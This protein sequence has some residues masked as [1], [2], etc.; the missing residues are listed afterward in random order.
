MPS[1]AVCT[2]TTEVAISNAP[3]MPTSEAAVSNAMPLLVPEGDMPEDLKDINVGDLLPDMRDYEDELC[4]F[5][6]AELIPD[7]CA[8]EPLPANDVPA[9]AAVQG[10]GL[11]HEDWAEFWVFPAIQD[12]PG[13]DDAYRTDE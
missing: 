13:A 9:D 6:F 7:Y 10:A 4:D 12:M 11:L 1:N 2:P 5:N 8:P 3:Y